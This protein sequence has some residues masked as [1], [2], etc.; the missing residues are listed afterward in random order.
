MLDRII[1]FALRNR[2]L[3][4][5]AALAVAALGTWTALRLPVDVLPDLNRPTVTVMTEV[6][7][8]VP[9]DV[10]RFVTRYVEQAV[11]GATG[12]LRVRSSSGMGLS[13]VWVEFDWGTDVYRNR[14][15]VQEK[16]QVAGTHLPPEATPHLAPI[17]SLMG[18]IQQIGI[19]SRSG[20]TDPTEIR[21]L[22]D[23]R[24][25]LRLLSIPGVAQVVSTGGAPRQLQAI[26]DADL[27]RAYDVTLAEVAEAIRQ[28]NVNASGGLM[29][30]GVRGPVVTV[31]GL[32]AERADLES[33][34][35]R[36]DAVRPVRLADV[37]RV[38]FGP[39]AVRT[40][41]AGVDGF[42]GVLLTITKQPDVDT[43]ALTARIDSELASIQESL[44]ADLEVLPSLY[45]QA[46]FIE[47]SVENVLDAVR[48][49]AVLVVIVLVLFLLNVRTTV[50][51]L[52]A[53]PLSLAATALVFA[54]MGISI[55]TMTLGGIA[56]AIGSLVDDA[57]VG[58]EN[59]FR[60][61]RENRAAAR[62]LASSVVV[63]LASSEVRRPI[64]I[65]TVVVAAVYLP[66]FALS[67]MEG[68][69]FTPIGIAYIVSILAS[70]AV[71]V[72]VTPVLSAWLLPNARA[73]EAEDGWLV[74]RL[75]GGAERLVRAG[76]ARPVATVTTVGALV[77]VAVAALATR[78]TEFLPP[79][80]E[81]AA[82]VNLVLPPGTSLDTSSAFGRRLEHVIRGVDGVLHL[83]RS[84]GRA[85]GDE[86]AHNVDFSL[87]LLSF[88]PASS[89]S[90]E[91]VI[92]EIRE[93]IAEA[94]PGVASST[95]QPL[96]HTLSHMLSGVNAQ[97]A[98][99]IFG[100]D[101]AVL[102]RAARQV[103]AAI[104]PLPGVT[105]V[106]PEP[107]VMV[108]RVEVRPRR[109]DLARLGLTVL[110]VANT[111]ELALEGEAV[112]RLVRGAFHHPIVVHLEA[113]DRKNLA[114]IRNLLVRTA[115]GHLL[116][117][118]DV[119]DV[120]LALTANNVSRENLS[121]R[122][123]VAHNVEGRSLGEVVK[124][125]ETALDPVR[126]DLPPGYAIRISGQFEA[127]E[128]ASRVMGV[129]F[130]AALGV[131]FFVLYLHFRSVN[132][133]L[134]TLASIPVSFLGA[135][136]FVVWSGQNLSVAT[137]VGLVA[138]G[139]VA[140]RN[141]ILLRDH[142]LHLMREEGMPFGVETIVRAGRQRILP[143]LLTA[144]T[145]GIALVPIVLSPG[146]P[147]REILYPVATVIVG[148]LVSSTLLDVLFTPAVF[149]L[150]G[151]RPAEAHA[152]R[153]DPGGD[154]TR[155]LA[156]ELNRPPGA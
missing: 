135:A 81:G 104:R 108:E 112:S 83:G 101:L 136:A 13:V 5:V 58:V 144:L 37:A 11:N 16:V 49:G 127:Q 18:Q 121:R 152:A 91:A 90:R 132:L 23:Q 149:W 64:L 118:G 155:R 15:I 115:D 70:L 106:L 71:A 43:L 105:D 69:L 39:A 117:L 92:Q 24:I 47:R 53:I 34:V 36:H 3:V 2:V 95:E 143:V 51:T 21:A 4:A 41:D 40:G 139:G 77:V 61:L 60:R 74:R 75:R 6:H 93:R 30:L 50:I 114:S 110:D 133:A 123:V 125:V 111:V 116:P 28:A 79:F 9:E 57:I 109:A 67:G 19:R 85:E 122:V 96:A 8:M 48:D 107:Q 32:V 80:N 124:D 119:A 145:S 52:T 82:V 62:P 147:G 14:Q 129:L 99:K 45:R 102:R 140:A 59:V 156:A 20:D 26:V 27:L 131:M 142:Y 46:D 141:T 76:L 7:G 63:F 94:F 38:E 72:V 88:D 78:G 65:G 55:N 113:K 98:I 17:S 138:L 146:Q 35:V 154:T 130:L 31:T 10:E 68:R 12:V 120:R 103:E 87:V 97:V 33:A 137:L 54:A 128:E 22:V 148:G 42:P 86:H 126:Q 100:E 66:L 150:F 153:R 73:V 29:P 151:R 25:K 1:A 89:R 44:P 134:Q 56:V 84:T